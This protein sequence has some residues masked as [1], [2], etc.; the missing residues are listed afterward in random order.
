MQT[1]QAQSKSYFVPQSRVYEGVQALQQVL[2]DPNYKLYQHATLFSLG[3]KIGL[4]GGFGL[5]QDGKADL[6]YAQ[7]F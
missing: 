6:L 7:P 5:I 2:R 3:G 1:A 4:E